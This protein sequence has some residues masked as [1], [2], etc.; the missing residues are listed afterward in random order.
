MHEATLNQAPMDEN[1]TVAKLKSEGAGLT[2]RQHHKH[3]VAAIKLATGLDEFDIWF[4]AL[5]QGFVG[6][7]RRGPVPPKKELTPE[8]LSIPVVKRGLLDSEAGAAAGCGGAPSSEE[9]PVPAPATK[10]HV[11]NGEDASVRVDLPEEGK[12]M[13]IFCTLNGR[14]QR[15]H[16]S[17]GGNGVTFDMATRELRWKSQW[18]DIH[19]IKVKRIVNF[20]G[21]GGR[22]EIL[23]RKTQTSSFMRMG[24]VGSMNLTK[25]AKMLVRDGVDVIEEAGGLIHTAIL[26]NCLNGALKSGVGLKCVCY[27]AEHYKRRDLCKTCCFTP[28]EAVIRFNTLAVDAAEFCGPKDLETKR[29]K[30]VSTQKEETVKVEPGVKLEPA[31]PVVVVKKEPSDD[32]PS[33]ASSASP[34]SPTPLSHR[35]VKLERKDIDPADNLAGSHI[36]VET[37]GVQGEQGEVKRRRTDSA[38]EDWR[39]YTPT[40]IDATRCMARTWWNGKGG[41]CGNKPGAGGRFCGGHKKK[42]GKPGWHGAVDGEIPA[43]KLAEFRTKAKP[44]ES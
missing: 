31:T 2:V 10:D 27:N 33:V 9:L 19:S 15:N 7:R 6:V 4:G 11:D 30:K 21:R 36:D 12:Y 32:T 20:V 42:E 39:K 44:R 5:G 13:I 24:E 3:Q 35:H 28:A 17:V 29:R 38:V 34:P 18:R 1:T 22:I 43:E 25:T 40:E 26:T 37:G 8:A 23:I 16:N 14:Q 41:Q